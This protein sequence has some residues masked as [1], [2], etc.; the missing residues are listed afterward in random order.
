[1]TRLFLRFYLGVVVILIAAWLIETYVRQTQN[2]SQNRRVVERALSGGFRLAR[3]E[4]VY[5][6][7]EGRRFIFWTIEQR[8]EYPV[9]LFGLSEDWVS[10]DVRMRLKD[11]DVVL[12]GRFVA[13][14]CMTN[15]QTKLPQGDE[16]DLESLENAG[17]LFGPL[18]QFVGPSRLERS[19]GYGLIFLLAALAIAVLLRPVVL[20]LRAVE[21]TAKAI[22]GGDL[23]ARIDHDVAPRGT[24]LGLAFNTMADQTESL[25]KSQRELLQA[26]SHELRTPLARIRFATELAENA[27]TAEERSERL[28]S[29]NKATDRLNELVGELLAY[30]RLDA[31][32]QLETERILVAPLL[33]EL[34]DFH[35]PLHPKIEFTTSEFD[36]SIT[37]NAYRPGLMRAIENLLSNAGYHATS[38]VRVG[39]EKLD[40]SARIIVEDDGSGI[41][42]ADREKIFEPFVRLNNS[43]SRVGSGLGL[44]LVSRIAKRSGG[45]VAVGESDLG[46]AKFE[47]VVPRGAD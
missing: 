23:S 37:V 36:D 34:I 11:G 21:R 28:E 5:T 17:L 35:Q 18:P 40:Q 31:G 41:A 45:N 20:Q 47:L 10:E 42:E 6:K 44:A 26:V 12:L 33:E 4:L 43:E 7:A 25:L 3:D 27:Q 39:V 1:M 2:E 46:G 19:L 14:A 32:T 30:V 9:K 29:I 8:F 13:I 24:A 38:T 15:K 22:A 16:Y